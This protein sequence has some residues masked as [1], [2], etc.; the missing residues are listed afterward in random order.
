VG[1]GRCQRRVW[2]KKVCARVY[3]ASH[4]AFDFS[5]HGAQSGLVPQR[6]SRAFAAEEREG[7]LRHP[8]TQSAYLGLDVN[9]SAC[10]Y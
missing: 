7:W 8:F 3:V 4:R 2:E 9:E 5:R 10:C 1:G 6:L